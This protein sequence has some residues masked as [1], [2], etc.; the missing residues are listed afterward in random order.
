MYN[1]RRADAVT[2]L[3]LMTT[4]ELVT[5]AA[6]A[7]DE[8]VHVPF[9][10]TRTLSTCVVISL[11]SGCGR[12][13]SRHQADYQTPVGPRWRFIGC[14]D[15]T[16][17]RKPPPSSRKIVPQDKRPAGDEKNKGVPYMSL[18]FCQISSGYGQYF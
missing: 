4:V 12:L 14:F 13:V 11:M 3:G 17:G 18:Y 15:V 9:V 2:L 7:P 5:A 10:V 8:K 6:A 1:R 16:N